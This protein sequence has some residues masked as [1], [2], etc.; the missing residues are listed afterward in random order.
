MSPKYFS[1]FISMGTFVFIIFTSCSKDDNPELK[2]TNY[3]CNDPACSI[4][5]QDTSKLATY[6]IDA[7][8]W[9]GQGPFGCD[10]GPALKAAS[11]GYHNVSTIHVYYNQLTY[12]LENGKSIDFLGGKLS[13][14][15]TFLT[16]SVSY[17]QLPFQSLRISVS[18]D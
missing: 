5:N 13:L 7:N 12:A 11:G 6:Y 17:N 4:P 2:K 9:G 14:G 1:Y 15:G 8:Q 3:V 16:F 18:V 10:F